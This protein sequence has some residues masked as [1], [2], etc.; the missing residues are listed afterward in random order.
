[1]NCKNFENVINDLARNQMMDVMAR[2]SALEHA[3]DC[4]QCAARL[5]N[6]ET[7]TLGLRALAM[8]SANVAAPAKVEAALLAAFRAPEKVV[9]LSAHPKQSAK[10]MSHL[11]KWAAAVAAAVVLAFF[12][13]ALNGSH[14]P[15]PSPGEKVAGATSPVNSSTTTL[16]PDKNVNEEIAVKDEP[17]VGSLNQTNT[18]ES[19]T[20]YA[21]FKRNSSRRAN[22]VDVVNRS[23]RGVRPVDPA[24]NA[25][26]AEMA[27]DF[28]PLT[29]D[30]AVAPLDSGHLVRVELP[31]TALLSMGLPMSVERQNEYVKAD[32]LMGEDGVARAIRFVR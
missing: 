14:W 18:K 19:L 20:Q 26:N 24:N 27:T 6:E 15:K 31:R 28:M 32:V 23:N 29:Y 10:S 30:A 11:W 13:F 25:G 2:E 1:M 12:T 17:G 7:L 5:A 4:T 9:M 3:K 8:Q 22:R 16:Q 21:S